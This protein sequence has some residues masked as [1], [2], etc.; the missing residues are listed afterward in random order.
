MVQTR[1]NLKT[2][3]LVKAAW[4]KALP[5]IVSIYSI[6]NSQIHRQKC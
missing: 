5:A 4:N 1:W 3:C 2:F 6:K